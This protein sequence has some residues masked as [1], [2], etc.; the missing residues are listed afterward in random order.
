MCVFVCVCVCVFFFIFQVNR[1][2][3]QERLYIF[4]FS[5]K[6]V[7]IERENHAEMSKNDEFLE[8]AKFYHM[9]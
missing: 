4:P 3:P 1:P 7:I 2:R 5:N 8:E 9:A 6:K